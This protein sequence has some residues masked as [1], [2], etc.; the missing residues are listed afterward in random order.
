TLFRED[1]I[2][3]TEE[4]QTVAATA[5]ALISDKPVQ[6]I[7]D[8]EPNLP[9]VTGDKRRI[10][11]ILLNL[12]SNAV[13]FTAQGTVTLSAKAHNGEVRFTIADT[14]S[15]IAKEDHAIIF[16]PFVQT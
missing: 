14:G 5:Q 6:F 8:L 3:L 10:R 2:D 1:N 4:L 9:G 16:D 13:K 7:A 11:Q 15:G 12:I